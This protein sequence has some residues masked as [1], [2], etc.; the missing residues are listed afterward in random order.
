MSP[1]DPYVY[2]GT[3]V[4]RNKFDVHDEA[5]LDRRVALIT[6][7]RLADL[8]A[9]PVH[10]QFDLAHLQSIHFYLFGEIYDWAGEIR[11]SA[12]QP[13]RIEIPHEPPEFIQEQGDYVLDELAKADHLRGLDHE[14]FTFQLGGY[15][16]EASHL[17]P[18]R[19]GNS[20]SQA[21]FFDQL[22]RNAGWAIDW[23]DINVD[24]LQA[25]RIFAVVDAG[26]NLTDVIAPAVKPVDDVPVSTLG[27]INRHSLM[28]AG[29]HL[30]HMVK[31][32]EN[33][34]NSTYT[35]PTQDEERNLKR[36]EVMHARAQL[37]DTTTV[38]H[39]HHS[40]PVHHHEAPRI[41]PDAHQP[42]HPL[43]H[44]SGPRL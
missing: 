21:V 12:T 27:Q 22:A 24:A 3:T 4:L 11:T 5:S 39:E 10:G 31:R 1:V 44:E 33:E 16:S 43:A 42:T 13:G 38:D 17:H 2:P 9:R 7:T 40:A 19:D 41:T 14:E 26:A 36:R 34:D 35:W 15:W 32:V 18:F 23:R 30:D 20:R 29:Q 28:N 6:A 25:A 8:A 37:R